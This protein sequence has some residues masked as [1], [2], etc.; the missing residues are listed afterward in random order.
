MCNVR[1]GNINSLHKMR[2]KWFQVDK[3]KIQN[4]LSRV[5]SLNKHKCR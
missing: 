2:K 4:R 5:K 3:K 1:W